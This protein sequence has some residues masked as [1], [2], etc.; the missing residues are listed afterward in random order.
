M[1]T[2]RAFLGGLATLPLLPRVALAGRGAGEARLVVLILR[3]GMDGLAAIPAVGDPHFRSARGAAVGPDETSALDGT[4]ALHPGLAPLLPLWK[5]DEAAIVHAVGTPYLER[6]HFDAQDVLETGLTTPMASRSGWLNRALLGIDA[7]AAR[8]MALGRTVPRLLQGDAPVTSADPTREVRP[9]DAFLAKVSELYRR[10]VA[11]DR[12]MQDALRAQAMLAKARGSTE[13][14]LVAGRGRADTQRVSQIMGAVLADPGG[15]RVAVAELSGW[16]T[17]VGQD[18]AL[19]RQLG[20]LSDA[21]VAL[22]ET[23]GSVWEHTVVCAVSEFGRTVAG[24]GTGGTDHGTG[25][26]ALLAGGALRGGRV[27]ADWPGLAPS[28]LLEGRDLRPTTDIRAVFKGLLRDHLGVPEG[29][30]ERVV[31]PDSATIEALRLV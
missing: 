17:H 12:A 22:Q 19:T 1:P 29:H 7:D 14:A 13:M 26:A 20:A 25:G 15:P 16:D 24:N 21:I 5:A 6:S 3:G 28:A 27:Y 31:F 9:Q 10:D 18:G 23:M 11:F 8:A 2:R 4:F 30:L